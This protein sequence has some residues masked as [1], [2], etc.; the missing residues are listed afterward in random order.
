MSMPAAAAASPG[1]SAKRPSV[2]A[3]IAND[4]AA[5]GLSTLK[6]SEMIAGLDKVAER[7]E[8]IEAREEAKRKA[9]GKLNANIALH[10]DD[11]GRRMSRMVYLTIFVVLV[12][13][14]GLG[15]AL[16]YFA[17]REIKDPRKM[18]AETQETLTKLKALSLRI[19]PFEDGDTITPE[20]VKEAFLKVID[21]DLKVLNE[22]IEK[23]KKRRE[24]TDKFRTPDRV[25]SADLA[26]LTRLRTLTNG[27]GAPLIITMSDADTISVAANLPPDAGVEPIEPVPIRVRAAKPAAPE[28]APAEKAS[29]K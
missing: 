17:N 4:R 8:K 6:P 5:L 21:A 11:T 25:M 3:G 16:F 28:K 15:A 23:D 29:P 1:A 12:S 7:A 13:I 18:R 27:W 14:V 9:G 2:K 20:K 24:K 22:E 26:N 10:T 19:S